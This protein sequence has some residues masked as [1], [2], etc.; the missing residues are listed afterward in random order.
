MS[1]PRGLSVVRPL[2]GAQ[3]KSA[4]AKGAG[5]AATTGVVSFAVAAAG[6]VAAEGGA[7]GGDAVSSTPA[8]VARSDCAQA[9]GAVSGTRTRTAHRTGR[10]AAREAGSAPAAPGREFR[11]GTARTVHLACGD[12]A[13]FTIPD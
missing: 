11:T 13:E 8:S 5:T 7:G 12:R 4:N 10:M 1:L 3:V 2:A 6:V 9:S